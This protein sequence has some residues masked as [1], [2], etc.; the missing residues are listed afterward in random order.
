M[1]VGNLPQEGQVESR[2]TVDRVGPAVGADRP[3]GTLHEFGRR[4]VARQLQGEVGLHAA[5]DVEPAAGE[6][7]PTALGQLLANQIGG[8]A[9]C[10]RSILPAEEGQHE[11]RFA[12]Q[13]RVAL[14]LG[15]PRSVVVLLVQQPLTGSPDCMP[16]RCGKALDGR[17]IGKR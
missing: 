12:L 1:F 15:T 3:P 5:A 16:D 11:D 8:R 6:L 7:G 10:Q 14:Q 13:D 2:K 9:P 4:V 17:T